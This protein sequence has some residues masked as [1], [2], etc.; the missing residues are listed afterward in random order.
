MN[1][2]YFYD[3]NSYRNKIAE[4]K[5]LP[6]EI[7]IIRYEH[8]EKARRDLLMRSKEQRNRLIQNNYLAPLG[9]SLQMSEEKKSFNSKVIV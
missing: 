6:K 9:S 2:L 4:I 3:F 1:D 5:F 7:Q 8:F